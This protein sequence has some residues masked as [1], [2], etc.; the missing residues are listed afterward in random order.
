[1]KHVKVFGSGCKRCQTT[2]S[3]VKDTAER[4]GV[5]VTVEK[6]TDSGSIAMAGVLS[7]PG[8]SVDGELVHTGGLPQPEK[9]EEWLSS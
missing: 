9:L 3:M 8:I 1:M 7:T 4:L 6:V 5:E 2:E